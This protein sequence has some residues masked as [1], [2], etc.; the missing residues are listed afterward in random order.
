M[1]GVAALQGGGR[2]QGDAAGPRMWPR[3]SGAGRATGQQ[4]RARS[5]R[6][7]T[8]SARRRSPAAGRPARAVSGCP[9]A[10]TFAVE[11]AAHHP[12]R[13]G[14]GADGPAPAARRRRA[15]PSWRHRWAWRR[16]HRRPDRA[17]GCPARDRSRSPPASGRQRRPGS[18]SRPRTAAGPRPN[19]RPGR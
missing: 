5:P 15:R 11:P 9:S 8:C 12:A 4:R 14:R 3:S 2:G 17:A 18:A 1:I 13:P 6:A 16:G 10:R 19:R 7:S